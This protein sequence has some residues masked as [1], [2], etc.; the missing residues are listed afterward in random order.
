MNAL[1]RS[2]TS[3]KRLITTLVIIAYYCW[4]FLRPMMMTPGRFGPAGFNP[5]K[6]EFPS[7]VLLNSS[8]F[9][10][11]AIL[12]LVMSLGLLG[13][14]SSFKASDVDVLFPTPVNPRTVLLFRIV[15]DYLATLLVPLFLVLVAWKPLNIEQFFRDV[16]HPQSAGYAI[17]AL[18]LATMLLIT[19]WVGMGYALSLYVNRNDRR[20]ELRKRLV[21]WGLALGF[22]G[23]F[24]FTIAKGVTF[25]STR[26]FIEFTNQ[27][28]LRSVFFTATPASWIVMGPL[29]GNNAEMLM[30]VGTL[31]AI[32]VGSLYLALKQASW[33][34]DQAAV[35]GF[36]AE[37]MRRMQRQGDMMGMMA[38]A[39]RRGKGKV[40]R[41]GW[42]QR[43]RVHGFMAL[44]WKDVLIQWRS[45]RV[46][47]GLFL[48]MGVFVTFMPRFL[49]PGGRAEGLGYITLMM[50]GFVAFMVATMT[51]QT[52]FTELLRRVDLQKPLPFG[53]HKIVISEVLAK[54]LPAMLIPTVVS[55]IGLCLFPATWPQV[56][57]GLIFF[58]SMAAVI[59]ALVCVIVL[60]FPEIDDVSQ[61][62][63]RG[64]MTLIF[65]VVVGA[66][67][68]IAFALIGAVSHS[69]IVGSIPGAIV[70][71]V[72]AFG[73]TA[74][75]GNL[76]AAFNPSE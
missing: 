8:V 4:F 29:D 24:L 23:L 59:C 73:L 47:I 53:P 55:V 61:R 63:F 40:R 65:L 49:G 21:G 27:G 32:A 71:Y 2:L 36:G 57:A 11:F 68:A 48:T 67:G 46:M 69:A 26:D 54:A 31:L 30:G 12:S 14:R 7:L 39:A 43:L 35:R 42:F 58:P 5:G 17:K 62:S 70:N 1:K 56:L 72:A 44:L 64:L 15:R 3:P 22:G 38:E 25:T 51:S 50:N 16:P 6:A 10:G 9:A 66:P 37:S 33:M 13:Y 18:S 20:S 45:V 52:G 34:Y 76:Y 19:S 60:L 28:W 41:T 75:G 74:V